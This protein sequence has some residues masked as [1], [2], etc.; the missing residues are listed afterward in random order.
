MLDKAFVCDKEL[1]DSV[2]QYFEENSVSYKK[3]V[4]YDTDPALLALSRAD[5]TPRC[6]EI[7]LPVFSS[8]M[9][10]I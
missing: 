5:S 7:G 8:D 3:A 1:A 6:C 2:C 10:F 4:N 9:I